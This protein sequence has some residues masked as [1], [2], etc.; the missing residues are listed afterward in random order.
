[1]FKKR[2][3]SGVQPTGDLH[4]G[5]Y[6]GAIKNF[7]KLQNV[8]E[9]LYCIVDLHALTVWQDPKK[10]TQSTREV[11]AAFIASGIDPKKNIIFNQSQ[12]YEHTQLAWIFN[13][14][15]R[16]GWLN[17]MTQFKDKAGKDKENVS[18]GLFS[19]PNLMAADILIYKATHV[20]V[21]E[22]QKQHLELCRDIA[23]KFN[24]DYKK[25]LFPI[26][27]P[28]IMDQ[29]AR[30]MSLRDGKN[31]MSKSDPSNY[32]RIMLMDSAEE[33]EQKIKKAKTDTMPLPDSLD[34]MKLRPE[35][36]NLITIYAAINN[37]TIEKVLKEFGNSKF[38]NFKKKLS[39]SLISALEPISIEMKKLIKDKDYLDSVIKDGRDQAQKI[40]KPVIS[41]VYENL[42]LLKT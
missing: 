21:G 26:I 18:V 23:Q 17:R 29:A 20:P 5:N 11:A 36:S 14:V 25:K 38:S 31:K 42:G 39:N 27:E 37:S 30:V 15:A 13:C 9:C 19:Y 34:S 10:L 28:I 22:D 35:A 32:S 41:E 40:A 1:M 4:L 16:M 3:L 2:I 7:V 8:Y 12:V 33:I 24:N 6:L